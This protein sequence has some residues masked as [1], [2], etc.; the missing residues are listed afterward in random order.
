MDYTFTDEE[1]ASVRAFSAARAQQDGGYYRNRGNIVSKVKADVSN[2]ALGE[3]ATKRLL[4]E[5]FPQAEV[6]EVDM[7]LHSIGSAQKNYK[8][9]FTL[10]FPGGFI[11]NVMVKM[12][13]C[14]RY[15]TIRP[16]WLFQKPGSGR[17]RDNEIA[18]IMKGGDSQ[19]LFVGVLGYCTDKTKFKE[20][21]FLPADAIA[22]QARVLGPFSLQTIVD[23]DIWQEPDA[24]GVR[25]RGYKR[26]LVAEELC[27]KIQPIVAI[28]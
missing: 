5:L 21:G 25:S 2:G 16:A 18:K 10:T 3:I 11:I 27:E 7:E 19:D 4:M 24:Y 17:H 13:L 20:D 1:K 26:A 15:K 6:S 12:H 28:A 22:D 23:E 9:D 14:G 8:A